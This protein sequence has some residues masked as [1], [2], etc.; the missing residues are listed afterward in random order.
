ML[1]CV[2]SCVVWFESWFRVLLLGV[3][4]AVLGAGVGFGAYD[5]GDCVM[6][7]LVVWLCF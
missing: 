5:C 3:F 2:V 1:W 7:W 4:V 6:V